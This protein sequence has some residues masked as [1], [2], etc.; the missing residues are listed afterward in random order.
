ML[1]GCRMEAVAASLQGEALQANSRNQSPAMVLAHGPY[2]N[3]LIAKNKKLLYAV[4][5]SYF[6]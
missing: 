4:N 3:I 1:N 2:F 5:T 6:I